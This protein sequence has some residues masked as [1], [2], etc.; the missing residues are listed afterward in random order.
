MTYTI[1]L[2]MMLNSFSPFPYEVPI[3]RNAASNHKNRK[4]ILMKLTKNNEVTILM[5]IKSSA[6]LFDMVW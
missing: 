4:L 6:L 5:G 1:Q 2:T 3:W